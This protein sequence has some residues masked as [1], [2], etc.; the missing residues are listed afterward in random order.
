MHPAFQ[1]AHIDHVATTPKGGDAAQRVLSSE[2]FA[3]SWQ[4][5]TSWHGYAPSPLAF[6]RRFGP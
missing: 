5:I 1:T 4:E 3:R 6:A 2:D